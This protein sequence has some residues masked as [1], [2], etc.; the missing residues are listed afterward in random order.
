M[1]TKNI[2]RNLIILMVLLGNIGCDQIS[3]NMVRQK[4]NDHQ[5]IAVF[6]HYF[7]LSKIEND[8]AF[9]SLGHAFPKPIKFILL[10]LLPIIA[11]ALGVYY[12]FTKPT[13]SKPVMV[14]ICFVLGGGIGN[15]YDR[16]LYGS[17]TD[18]MH[19]NFVIFQTGIFNMAD[20]SIMVGGFMLLIFSIE[21]K[22]AEI[23]I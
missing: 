11:L 10:L 1:K 21:K 8:G 9:L 17:V 5:T 15:L 19:I 7:T 12:V 22:K 14:G 20:V 3:K 2:L 4:I 13:I 18:F 23:P 16:I 6:T